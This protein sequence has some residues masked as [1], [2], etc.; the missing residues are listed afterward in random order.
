LP[1]CSHG[2]RGSG[3]VANLVRHDAG[4]LGSSFAARI[5]PEF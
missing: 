5:K 3:N 2:R 4:K 1:E